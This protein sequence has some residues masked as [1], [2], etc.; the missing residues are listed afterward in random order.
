MKD[1]EPDYY[2]RL[3]VDRNADIEEIRA[4][5]RKMAQK[6]HPDHVSG[7]EGEFVKIRR[8]YETLIDASLRSKYDHYLDLLAGQ[9][10]FIEIKPAVRD[11]YDDMVGYLKEV[12]G[13]RN[14]MEYEL[15]LKKEVGDKDRIVRIAIPV[16]TICRRCLGTGGTLFGECSFC[17]G[18]GKYLY[19]ENVDLL[20]P[21]GSRDGE[22]M[23]L[24]FPAQE[25]KL[26]LR[27]R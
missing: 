11:L 4:A 15:V 3:Q 8:A 5:F 23:I 6:Y 22:Q 16:E 7:D 18:K 17:K 25:V 19:G 20:I 13:F 1:F 21:S 12:I 14:S 27:L 24:T 2:E 10:S 9:D 26:T